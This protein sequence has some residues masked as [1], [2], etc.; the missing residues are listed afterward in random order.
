MASPGRKADIFFNRAAADLGPGDRI[1]RQ[2]NPCAPTAK[3]VLVPILLLLVPLLL[4]DFSEGGQGGTPHR[5]SH[6]QT[7]NRTGQTLF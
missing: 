6:C 4:L 2:S 3:S 5:Q 1:G 7:C